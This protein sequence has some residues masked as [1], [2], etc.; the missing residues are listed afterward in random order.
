MDAIL[1][2]FIS[3]AFFFLEFSASF[4]YQQYG[5]SIQFLGNSNMMQRQL[6]KMK[7]YSALQKYWHKKWSHNK[8]THNYLCSNKSYHSY[9][10]KY[11]LL[12]KYM[13]KNYLHPK[14]DIL[15]KSY[16]ILKFAFSPLSPLRLLLSLTSFLWGI[17]AAHICHSAKGLSTQKFR[18][19]MTWANQTGSLKKYIR[20][21]STKFQQASLELVLCV[22]VLR[23]QNQ[24]RIFDNR[25][26]TRKSTSQQ[27]WIAASVRLWGCFVGWYFRG[28]YEDWQ[29]Y[30]FCWIPGYLNPT[31]GCLCRVKKLWVLR[32]SSQHLPQKG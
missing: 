25:I 8:F 28:S 21:T 15:E 13:C 6:I 32:S 2:C 14:T 5:L 16:I 24:T 1:W 12:K 10:F 26:H 20:K 31:P 27:L 3:Q 9:F 11:Y 30:E 23:E 29:T 17:N 19:F 7:K 18:W 4:F 22:A